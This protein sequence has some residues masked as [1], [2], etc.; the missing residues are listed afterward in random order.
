MGSPPALLRGVDQKSIV[1]LLTIPNFP[2]SSPVA[3]RQHGRRPDPHRIGVPARRL[4]RPF[5]ACRSKWASIQPRQCRARAA[6]HGLVLSNLRHRRHCHARVALVGPQWQRSVY[7]GG[8][9]GRLPVAAIPGAPG[10]LQMLLYRT[11]L[12]RLGPQSVQLGQRVV[13]YRNVE[14]RRRR[15]ARNR[16]RHALRA[17]GPHAHRRRRPAQTI[18]AQMHPRSHLHPVGRRHHVLRGV[19]QRPTH[20]HRRVRTIGLRSARHRVVFY[21]ISGRPGHGPATISWIAGI[22]VDNAGG[23]RQATGTGA[24]RW[25]GFCPTSTAGTSAG[26]T[27]PPCCAAPAVFEYP[28]VDREPT[29]RWVDGRVA[30]RRCRPRHTPHRLN[31]ASQPIVDARVLGAMMLRWR[32]P[33]AL[34]AYEKMRPPISALVRATGAVY[35]ACS[36]WWT[37]AVAGCSTTSDAVVP[38]RSARPSWRALLEV[39]RRARHRHP[40]RRAAHHRTR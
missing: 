8:C 17:G 25:K 6:R 37:S 38:C 34:A 5:R 4:L 36:T 28:M 16:V 32:P 9:T 33:E 21:P 13:G 14:E 40:Q 22:T 30:D 24:W 19:T 3:H 35:S 31:G 26:W 2:Y 15:A 18:R 7:C 29:S 27:C 10:Q 39:G 20:P 1:S 12:E 11:V 23:W